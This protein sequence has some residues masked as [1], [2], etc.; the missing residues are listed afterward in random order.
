MVTGP[1]SVDIAAEYAGPI[2]VSSNRIS[3]ELK[4]LLIRQY[5]QD[6]SENM[7]D[8]KNEMSVEDKRFMEIASSSAFLKD[9]HYHLPLP[10]RDKAKVMPENYHTVK[11]R[12]LHLM[13]KFKKN[14]MYAEEYTSFMEDILKKGYAEKVPPQQLH[15]EDGR[16]WYILHHGVYH[17]RKLK[18]RVVFD[19]T[20]SFQGKSLNKELLQGPDLTNTLIGVLLRFRQEQ[21]AV[22]ADIE[23]MFYQVH[24]DEKDRDFLRFLWWPEGDISKPLGVYRMKVHLFGAVSSPSIANF[25]LRQTADDKQRHYSEVMKTIK[26]NFYV[27]DCLRSVATADQA[28]KLVKDLTEACSQGGFT[29]TKWVSNNCEVLASIPVHHRAKAVKELDLDKEKLKEQIPV[30]PALGIHWNTH[31][32]TFSFKVTVTSRPATRRGILSTVSSV[33]DPLG[34]LS[35]FILKAKQ[36]LQE[37]CKSRYGWDQV[38]PQEFA[39]PWHRWMEELNQLR[40]FQVARC[41]KPDNFDPVET[42]ELH[43]FCDASESGYG[44]VSYLRLTN[45]QG[46]IHTSFIFGKAR[47][48]PL[49]QITI[50]R[51]ELTAATLAVKV[52]RMLRKELHLPFTDSTFWTDSTSVL[53]Y[54]HNQT[55]R[56]HTF[57]SNRVAVIQD[58]SHT[59]QWRYI[60]S[61]ENPADSASRGLHVESFLRSRWL[62]GPEYLSRERRTW[63]K[64]TQGL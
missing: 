47:V 48:S 27:D 7:Y 63:P 56:F 38:I 21:I 55:K 58:L 11:E 32:D 44:T 26:T 4:D 46:I 25:A 31:S 40:E 51:L 43:H 2:A 28:I 60:S 8:E 42:A 64:V 62:K 12:T 45:H 57:V 15:R 10:F 1:L 30:E 37:L 49:K 3:V 39:R 29:L 17:K 13:K 24:V 54:I 61:K 35:P 22:M 52:D 33:Y 19:C 5:N 23:A 16:V 59:S 41:I 14:K 18:L 6:F 9:G 36:L 34:F 53:K 50:P 20:S